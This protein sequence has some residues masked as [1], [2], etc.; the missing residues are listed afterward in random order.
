MIFV[1]GNICRDTTFYLSRLP[2][3]GETINAGSLS[4]DLGGKGLNQA[5]AASN[6]GAAVRLVAGVGE[7]WTAQ[8]ELQIQKAASNRLELSLAR[9]AGPVDCSF[10]MVSAAGENVIVTRAAQAESLSISDASARL[11]FKPGDLLLLQCN[12]QPAFTLHAAREAKR[13]GARVVFNPA[14]YKSWATQMLDVVDVAIMNRQEATAWTGKGKP[15]QAVA[16]LELPAAIITLGV[17]GC[18][19]RRRGED[20]KHFKASLVEAVD[21]TGAG[22][23]FVGTFAAEWQSTGDEWKAIG[24][25]IKAASASVV[26]AGALSSIPSRTEIDELRRQ[27]G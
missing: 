26:R 18:I 10:I 9:K 17:E 4:V 27:S 3:P 7:D 8:D 20:A 24:L 22:D 6:A 19:G 14:P 11:D 25:A 23:T 13:S 5:V 1:L 2:L 16:E 21:T 15:A 12:L